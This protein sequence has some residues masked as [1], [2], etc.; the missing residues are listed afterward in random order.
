MQESLPYP[1]FTWSTDGCST[2]G[3]V[4]LNGQARLANDTSWS[5]ALSGSIPFTLTPD[6]RPPAEITRPDIPTLI[7]CGPG[8]TF[9]TCYA[10]GEYGDGPNDT[11]WR[12]ADGTLDTQWSSLEHEKS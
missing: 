11:A 10:N 2:P 4:T 6:V 9:S 3:Q 8:F 5:N 7:R 1:T 12:G